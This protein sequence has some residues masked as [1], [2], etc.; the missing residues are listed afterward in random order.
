MTQEEFIDKHGKETWKQLVEPKQLHERNEV[1][2]ANAN[3]IVHCDVILPMLSLLGF[4]TGS[5]LRAKHIIKNVLSET[6][7]PV[8]DMTGY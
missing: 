2:R 4:K 3:A 1:L 6:E 8:R 5:L 7:E